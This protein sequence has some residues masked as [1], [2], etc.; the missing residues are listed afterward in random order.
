MEKKFNFVYVTT[1]LIN[2]K[3]YIGDHSTDKLNDYYFGS[4][5]YLEQSIKK[6]GRKNF[7][8][9]ILEHFE[10]KQDA[11]D[12]QEKYIIEYNTLSPNGY[13]LSPKGGHQ[14]NNSFSD[15]TK[16]KISKKR[17]LQKPTFLGK[18][19]SDE[20]KE[21]MKNTHTGKKMSEESKEKNRIKH[22]K[23]N[24]SNE[25]IE[26]MK[27]P[28]TE[29]HK[30]KLKDSHAHLSGENHPMYGKEGYWKDKN[31]SEETRNKMSESHKGKHSGP[32]SEK[33]RLAIIEGIRKKKEMLIQA[34]SGL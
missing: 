34:S 17:K 16:E 22:L 8:V 31:L 19:H 32:I 26:K 12:N 1:N 28:K 15:E 3:Q 25:I 11:F 33:H 6:Y 30:Q 5:I 29:E 21:K 27:G 18:N 7:E 9:K 2:G 23:E 13:N 10:N 20:T 14:C 24:L 4:G